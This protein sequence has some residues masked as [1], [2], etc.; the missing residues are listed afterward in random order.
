MYYV[1]SRKNSKLVIKTTFV[2]ILN[3]FPSC[4]YE[5]VLM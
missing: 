5:V 2:G 4:D 1:Y 3:L